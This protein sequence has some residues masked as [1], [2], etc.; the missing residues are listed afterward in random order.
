MSMGSRLLSS[1]SSL[2]LYSV[3]LGL[4]DLFGFADIF[5]MFFVD[6]DTANLN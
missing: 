4:W 6:S 2:L 5:Y 3:P 1:L